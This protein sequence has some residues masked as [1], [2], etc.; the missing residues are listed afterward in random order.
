MGNG[1]GNAGY[2]IQFE[3][4]SRKH[5]LGALGMARGSDLNSASCQFYIC[6]AP[7]PGLDGSYV[8]FGKVLE[9]MDA[10]KQL[11]AGDT[12]KRVSISRDTTR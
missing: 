9:G 10:V 2:N 11:R 3:S 1:R 4:N 12:I 8:V 5:E 6:L 7:Q